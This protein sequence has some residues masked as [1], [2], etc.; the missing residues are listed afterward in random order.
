M[1]TPARPALSG[2]GSSATAWRTYAAALTGTPIDD[3]ES[4]TRDEIIADLQDKGL[5]DGEGAPV[6]QETTPTPTTLPTRTPTSIEEPSGPA[7]AMPQDGVDAPTVANADDSS[8][9]PATGTVDVPCRKCY[10][11]GWPTKQAGQSASCH[12]GLS[13][14]YG[15]QLEIS[16]ELAIECGFLEE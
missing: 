3:W 9:V 2:P 13:I 1:T 14:I 8:K 5:L 4:L 7:P 15:Q 10:P 11:D 12:H 16:R 6:M